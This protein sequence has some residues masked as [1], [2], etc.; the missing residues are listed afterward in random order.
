MGSGNGSRAAELGDARRTDRLVKIASALGENPSVSLPARG[1]TRISAK[2]YHKLI[3]SLDKPSEVMT[4]E[5]K[6][7][8][9]NA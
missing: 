6:S 4:A 1:R 8:L 5:A 2:I 3:D 9:W 7:G